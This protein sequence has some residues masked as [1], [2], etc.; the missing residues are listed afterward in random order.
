MATNTY[1]F[2]DKVYPASFNFNPSLGQLLVIRGSQVISES[3]DEQTLRLSNGLNLKLNG[4]FQLDA[5][6]HVISGT[7]ISLELSRIGNIL[8][9]E[10]TGLS[11]DFQDFHSTAQTSGSG[12]LALCWPETTH[13][14]APPAMMTW[15]EVTATTR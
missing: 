7:I 9:Q 10:L 12:A 4:T 13:S 8:V 3:A 14:T 5:Q 11:V 2:A 1:Y 6:G 15:S